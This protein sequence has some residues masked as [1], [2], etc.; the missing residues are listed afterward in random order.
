MKRYCL[1]ICFLLIHSLVH[2]ISFQPIITPNGISNRKVLS[3]AKDREGYIWVATRL[4]LDRYNGE[5]FDYYKYPQKQHLFT[6][7]PKGIVHDNEGRIYAFSQKSICKFSPAKNKFELYPNFHLLA[8]EIIL[9]LGFSPSNLLFIGTNKNIYIW[10]THS[11]KEIGILPVK[12]FIYSF[13]FYKNKCYIGSS[14]GIFVLKYKAKHVSYSLSSI[15][16][17]KHQRVQTLFFDQKTNHLWIGTFAN[18]LSSYHIYGKKEIKLKVKTAHPIR[19]ITAINDSLL[20]VGIDG[21]GIYEM[22][23]KKQKIINIFNHKSI[24][25]HKLPTNNIYDILVQQNQIWIATYNSGLYVYNRNQ[26]LV[27]TYRRREGVKNSLTNNMV[28]TTFEDHEKNLWMGTNLG[29]SKYNSKSNTWQHFLQRKRKK[30]AVILTI[31][32]DNNNN[33]WAGG[34]A[35]DLICISSKTNKVK[36]IKIPYKPHK[37]SYI[38][39]IHKDSIFLWLG[40]IINGLT[41]YNT[42]NN[43]FKTYPLRGIQ[44]MIGYNNDSLL[45]ASNKGLCFFDKDKEKIHFI[46]LRSMK[47]AKPQHAY[48]NIT[49]LVLSRNKKILWIGTEQD[50]LFCY[51]IQKQKLK[52]YTTKQGL[53]SNT[54]CGI[55]FDH[56][57][58]LWIGTEKGLSC[59][60]VSNSFIQNFY[61][62]DGLPDNF[63][64]LRSLSKR[65]NGNL[66]CGTPKGAFEINPNKFISTPEKKINLIL[67]KFKLYYKNVT[68]EDENSP[69]RKQ[70]NRTKKI[71]L[72][73]KQNSFAFDFINLNYSNQKNT[74]YQWRLKGLENTWHFK[75]RQ[76]QAVYNNIPPGNYQ[77]EIKA[78][79][80]GYENKAVKRSIRIQ[81]APPFWDSSI[82]HFVYIIAFILIIY[83]GITA[84]IEHI[85]NKE[86]KQRIQFFINIAHDLRTP[87]TLIKAPLDE[88]KEEQNLSEKGL[89][90]LH[91]AQRNVK[92]LLKMVT[93]LLDFQKIE[94][95]AMSLQIQETE[96]NPFLES[97]ITN[98]SLAAK[99]KH[100]QIEIQLP[101]QKECGWI[102][103]KKMIIIL[104]NL[105]SNAI[106]YTPK[107][108]KISF[109]ANI[110]DN[111]LMM[112]VS[113]N[114]IGISAVDQK[115]LFKR[116]YRANNAA[117]SNETGSGI[118]LLLTQKTV[119]LH[120][121]DIKVESKENLGTSFSVKIPI[122]KESYQDNEI[123][124]IN[125]QT[126]DKAIP[127]KPV[128]NK[129][130]LLLV[131]DN[132]ELRQYLRKYLQQ[133]Y[134]VEEAKDG[135]E[136][137]EAIKRIMPDFI[138]SDVMMPNLSGIELCKILKSDINTCH[139]PII[140]LT[141]LAEKSDMMLGFN[142]GADDYI[143]KPFELALLTTKIEA[144]IKNRN[145]YRKKY[146][147]KTALKDKEKT[148]NQLDKKF[149]E[150][151][152]SFIEE[153]ITNE[154]FNIDYV[155]SE[156]AMSRTVFYKKIKSLTGLKPQELIKDVKMK[157]AL[158]LLRQEKYS[159]VEIA[160]MSGYPN[161]KYFSTTFKKYYGYSPTDFIHKEK[162]IT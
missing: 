149:M 148:A 62:T 13:A 153:N 8:N 47:G 17:F 122:N 4:G 154:Q 123:I 102:D 75:T 107:N 147:D 39:A 41:R 26:I 125:V 23:R 86:S 145:R 28:N 19:K 80:P 126:T 137:I 112:Q 134:N 21:N 27:K 124:K 160:E 113:D 58:R 117:N 42:K 109:E 5:S 33:I 25:K 135:D 105:L 51:L 83:F 127:H 128:L 98:F 56:K 59:L 161:S 22:H 162:E 100:L 61:Q 49:A 141:S 12:S 159:I 144:I 35:N 85:K 64:L 18:G 89:G 103:R 3:I 114:G 66:L 57:K 101:K 152:V 36:A 95:E 55:E 138:L 48:P 60:S 63:I 71:N 6:E 118:G 14:N 68:I 92:S 79:I 131:E 146:I 115:N 70:I 72:N 20:W 73:Y 96:I 99:E 94:K 53:P 136:A 151:V 34:Y 129:I 38:Y 108:G 84:Y 110:K 111:I 10:D 1:F 29:L 74:Y 158:Q 44:K 50:G 140:L 69:L 77:F 97:C 106:K 82:A 133:K 81:I 88:L 30:H 45:I 2:A 78:F 46:N 104:N 9:T 143:T 119:F 130:N 32:E 157:K 93:Q 15:D 7:N 132:N 87:L 43:S 142:A 120:K 139:I 52:Q 156:M 16:G 76:H 24:Q 150:K 31:I 54:I 90:A 121:G 37:K 91:L 65:K 40:G 116:F 155:A 11:N 67:E